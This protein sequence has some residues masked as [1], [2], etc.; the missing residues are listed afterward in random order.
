MRSLFLLAISFAPPHSFTYFI[1]APL[2]RQ[3]L[4]LRSIPTHIISNSIIIQQPL[5]TP[6]RTDRYVLVPQ[7]PLRKRHHVLLRDSS[8]HPL[9]LHG[10]HSPT[11]RDDLAANVFCDGGCAVEGQQ[12][13]GFELRFGALDFCFT[14][15]DGEAG[16][17]AQ[18]EVD[19]VVDL[20]LVFGDEVDAPEARIVNITRILREGS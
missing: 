8:N 17:F 11:G 5:N 9:D 15:I 7:L 12:D 4:P 18:G 14:H 19:E 6:H 16:P 13:G 20:G 1:N 2:C 3:F 10:I